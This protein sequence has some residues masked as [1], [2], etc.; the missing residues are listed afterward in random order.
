[1]FDALAVIIP[2]ILTGFFVPK[3]QAVCKKSYATPPGKKGP[4]GGGWL[5][6]GMVA[7]LLFV[8]T[9]IP[10]QHLPPHLNM[11]IV[12]Q[13][14]LLSL[15]A[16]VLASFYRQTDKALTPPSRFVQ[17]MPFVFVGIGAFFMPPL[18]AELS[19]LPER[20]LYMVIWLVIMRAFTKADQL[21]GLAPASMIVL[22]FGLALLLKALAVPALILAGVC[23]GFLRFN[24]PEAIL[25][26]GASGRRWLGF[27]AGGLWLLAA[28]AVPFEGQI[29][30]LLILLLPLLVN[31]LFTTTPWH[32]RLQELG[33]SKG[34]V[35]ARAVLAQIIM[36]FIAVVA[37]VSAQS[38]WVFLVAA[39]ALS[40]LYLSYIR[41]LERG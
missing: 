21:D 20:A 8:I 35:L 16:I 36:L 38:A 39:F 29:F 18:L 23:M 13:F 26:L 30:A 32:I 11:A 6:A 1:M 40:L 9:F 19:Y 7:L 31:N 3:W 33:L 2:F 24:R 4:L 14:S 27:M 10:P 5:M 22:C 12:A 41:W 34:Q 15:L 17:I 25:L 37:F 28:S